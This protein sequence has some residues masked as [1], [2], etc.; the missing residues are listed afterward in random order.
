MS[1]TNF[2]LAVFLYF[3]AVWHSTTAPKI[4]SLS[5]SNKLSTEV[6]VL[7]ELRGKATCHGHRVDAQESP[8]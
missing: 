8:L 4:H 2:S 3:V 1:Y 5:S 7:L 6:G